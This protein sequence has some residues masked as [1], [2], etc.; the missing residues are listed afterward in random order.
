MSAGSSWLAVVA[1][2]TQNSSRSF[3]PICLVAG[4]RTV[5]TPCVF[6]PTHADQSPSMNCIDTRRLWPRCGAHEVFEPSD[7]LFPVI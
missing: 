6:R 4:G 7:D 3:S 5:E 2:N 1:R